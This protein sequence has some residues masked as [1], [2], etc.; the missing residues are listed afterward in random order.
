MSD[1]K[2]NPAPDVST[3]D[4]LRDALYQANAWLGNLVNE[5]NRG[6]NS[7]LLAA[8]RRNQVGD[9]QTFEAALGFDECAGVALGCCPACSENFR[10]RKLAEPC[11]K[12]RRKE[13]RQ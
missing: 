13:A 10:P 5:A 6:G 3:E 7:E 4:K 12:C 9:L 1:L 8:L 2:T 11:P